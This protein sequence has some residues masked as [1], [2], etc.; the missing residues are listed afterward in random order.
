MLAGA[1]AVAYVVNEVWISGARTGDAQEQLAADFAAAQQAATT[2][3]TTTTPVEDDPTMGSTPP[4][5]TTNPAQDTYRPHQPADLP[6]II[7][8]EPPAPTEAWTHPHRRSAWIG[9]WSR[10][11]TEALNKGPGHAPPPCPASWQPWS[12]HRTTYGA[13]FDLDPFSGDTIQIE[14]LIGARLRSSSRIIAPP[15][16]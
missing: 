12:G 7:S 10:V 14:T 6:A 4:T 1:A 5:S 15:T 16:V 13:P 8:A 3:T 9:S 11:S 2:T